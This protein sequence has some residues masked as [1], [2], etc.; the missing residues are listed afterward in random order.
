MSC[1]IG[2]DL[3][4]QSVKVVMYDEAGHLLSWAQRDYPISTP[5][6]GYAEQEPEEWW[7]LTFSALQEVIHQTSE[8]EIKALSFSG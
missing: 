4:T 2:I 8:R 5:Q 3:G 1:F 6:I 7:K